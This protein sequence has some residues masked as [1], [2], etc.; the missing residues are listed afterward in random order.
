[1]LWP[2]E[3]CSIQAEIA[4]VAR[5]LQQSRGDSANFVISALILSMA[6]FPCHMAHAGLITT[7]LYSPPILGCRTSNSTE[8]MP[9][10]HVE[11]ILPANRMSSPPFYKIARYP[12]DALRRILLNITYSYYYPTGV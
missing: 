6:S 8:I 3:M 4:F 2:F 7:L 12:C 1:M 11:W 10:A 5:G 9:Q